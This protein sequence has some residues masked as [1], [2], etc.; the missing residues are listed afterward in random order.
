MQKLMTSREVSM[1][2][3]QFKNEKMLDKIT[4]LQLPHYSVELTFQNMS[5][6]TEEI[7]ILNAGRLFQL[8]SDHHWSSQFF[9]VNIWTILTCK[10][11][12]LK[13]QYFHETEIVFES[14]KWLQIYIHEN[15]TCQV[16]LRDS[17]LLPGNVLTLLFVPNQETLTEKW[18]VW[19]YPG[20]FRPL[21]YISSK[22]SGNWGLNSTWIRLEFWRT[23]TIL[24]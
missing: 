6:H 24:N 12:E 2:P 13:W 10:C 11:L 9:I 20:W 16:L 8:R 4:K 22:S 1:L 14:P 18:F 5:V 3:D 19:R 15:W 23:P 7:Y 17:H 21:S